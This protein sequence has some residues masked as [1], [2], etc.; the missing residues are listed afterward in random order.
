MRLTRI[1]AATAIEA[2]AAEQECIRKV[3]A[4][5]VVVTTMAVAVVDV[6]AA[7]ADIKDVA[8]AAAEE[9]TINTPL[10]NIRDSNNKEDTNRTTITTTKVGISTNSRGIRRMGTPTKGLHRY[11]RR[12][13]RGE[14]HQRLRPVRTP[15]LRRETTIMGVHRDVRPTETTSLRAPMNPIASCLRS[16]WNQPWGCREWTRH[17]QECQRGARGRILNATMFME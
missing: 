5:A 8:A 7:V 3:A 2:A 15:I 17:G 11:H 12:H 4:A 14:L 6:A 13:R 10:I 1:A 16:T 9:G